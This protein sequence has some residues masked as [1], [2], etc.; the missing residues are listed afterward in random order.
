MKLGQIIKIFRIANNYS[1]KQLGEK[2]GTSST[3]IN[4][5][6]C[7]GKK[8]SLKMLNKISDAFNVPTSTLV[9]IWEQSE[10]NGWDFQKTLFET[11]KLY[12]DE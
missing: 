12:F 5:L 1:T 10:D 7:S 9:K 4:E 6:E 11:L 8:P 3:Y 2:M